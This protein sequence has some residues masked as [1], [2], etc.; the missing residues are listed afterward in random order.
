MGLRKKGKWWYGDSQADIRG[1]LA[2]IGKLNEDVP[3]QF[4]DAECSCGSH[5]FRLALDEEQGAAIRTCSKCSTVHPIGDSDEYLEEAEP[6][7]SICTCGKD[8]F[9]IT[10]G[11]SL[12]DE[13]DDVRW[14]YVGC[15]CSSC[16]VT[17][18]YGDWKNE[19]IDYRELL[20]RV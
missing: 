3:T 14:F 11:V 18:C 16:G 17:G 4:A 13:S 10:V 7:P 5:L 19:F 20:K 9:E 2:R 1:E 12:Y 6:Q 15:R 8:V